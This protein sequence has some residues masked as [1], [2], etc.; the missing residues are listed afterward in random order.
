MYQRADVG[1][2]RISLLQIPDFLTALLGTVNSERMD[3]DSN[4]RG[5]CSVSDFTT[6]IDKEL[7]SDEKMAQ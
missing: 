7:I 4:D 1:M 5:R 6:S 2:S 3:L